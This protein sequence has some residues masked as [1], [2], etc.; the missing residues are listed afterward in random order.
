VREVA[1]KLR[2]VLGLHAQI[3]LAGQ[4][5][6]ELLREAHGVRQAKHGMQ[7]QQARAEEQERAIAL[8][9]GA[10]VGAQHLHGHFAAVEE[11]CAV[12]LGHAGGRHRRLVELGEDG[13]EGLIAL[14]LDG[15]PHHGEGKRRQVILQLLE[16]GDECRLE[17]VWP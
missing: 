12:Y 3:R 1:G 2:V 8:H 9:L 10:H 5:L 17:E 14:G 16:F 4:A 11:A 13:V 7:G 6:H 15:C